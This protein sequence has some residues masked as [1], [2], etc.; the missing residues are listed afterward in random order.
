[1]WISRDRVNQAARALQSGFWILLLLGSGCTK[2]LVKE[3]FGEFV[4]TSE[5]D[6]K[7]VY[8]DA[9]G[10]RFRISPTD[11]PLEFKVEDLTDGQE[12]FQRM[13]ISSQDPGDVILGWFWEE[14]HEAWILVRL[15]SGGGESLC[16]MQPDLD[17]LRAEATQGDF[18]LVEVEK[19]KSGSSYLIDGKIDPEYWTH[20]DAWA[21]N[22]VRCFFKE[23]TS[24][25]E[26][27]P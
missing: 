27:R 21:I 12:S 7:P 1:M 13:R 24:L 25:E 23:T 22:Q 5:L 8:Y 26:K 19:S 10:K 6:E 2:I 11:N 20:N 17:T 9:E 14:Q 16:I 4:K 15:L 3:P 18:T